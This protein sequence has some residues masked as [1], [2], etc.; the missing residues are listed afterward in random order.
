MLRLEQIFTAVGMVVIMLSVTAGAGFQEPAASVVA[1]PQADIDALVTRYLTKAEEYQKAFLNLTAEE[2]RVVETFDQSGRLDKRREIVSDLVVYQARNSADATEY[3]DVG[4]V[5]GK[6]I[7]KRGK[8]ALELLARASQ[9]DSFKKELEIIDRESERYDLNFRFNGATYSYGV[10]LRERQKFRIDW[11]GRDHVNGHD[12]VVIDYQEVA[13][14]RN[15]PDQHFYELFGFTASIVRGRLWID[16]ATFQL[17]RERWEFAGIHPALPQP[18]TSISR[19]AT[20]TESRFGILVPERVVFGFWNAKQ[21]KNQPP[22]FFRSVRTTCT[23]GVFKQFEVST[24][25]TIGTPAS[26]KQ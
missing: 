18:V 22:S 2:T 5:D 14:N 13:P 7:K 16:A 12:V 23:Y 4:S 6:P 8:R 15:N 10:R 20:Y 26:P 9:S 19:E 17:R 21:T 11:A 1:P 24:Q 3:R 25:Q